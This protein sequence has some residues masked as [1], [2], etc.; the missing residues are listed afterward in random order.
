MCLKGT[1]HVTV[2]RLL[3]QLPAKQRGGRGGRSE[4]GGASPGKEQESPAMAQ[5]GVWLLGGHACAHQ[6]CSWAPSQPLLMGQPSLGSLETHR[7]AS[8]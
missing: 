1:I 7:E 2:T 5:S 4:L 6:A 3:S 8:L